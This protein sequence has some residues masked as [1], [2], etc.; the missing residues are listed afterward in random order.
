MF[1]IIQYLAK[2][3]KIFQIFWTGQIVQLFIEEPLGHVVAASHQYVTQTCPLLTLVKLSNGV[4]FNKILSA[5]QI[6]F[7]LLTSG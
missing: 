7:F 5:M 4:C 1:M 3:L 2:V 6:S